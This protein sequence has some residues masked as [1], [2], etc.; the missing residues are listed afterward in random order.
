MARSTYTSIISLNGNGL[1]ALIKRQRLADWTRTQEPTICCL[2]ET[3]FR[4]KHT[5]TY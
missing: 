1:S 2:Q 5:N 4:V 3:L